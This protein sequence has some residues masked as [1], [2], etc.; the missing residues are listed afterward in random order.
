MDSDKSLEVVKSL[1]QRMVDFLPG[2]KDVP[3]D[4]RMAMAQIAVAHGLDPFLREVWP[5]P[6]RGGGFDLFIGISGW[7]NA[8]HRSGE[9]WGRRF[10]KVSDEERQWLGAAKN[11]LAVRCI[12]MRRKTG[13]QPAE[14]DGYGIA[15]PDEQSKMNKF[16]LARLRAERD[17]MKAAFP[18]STPFNVSVQVASDDDEIINGEHEWQLTGSRI[19]AHDI[20]ISANRHALGRDDGDLTGASTTQPQPDM[21]DELTQATGREAVTNETPEQVAQRALAA[22]AAGTAPAPETMQIDYQMKFNALCIEKN[23]SK[24]I[25]DALLQDAGGDWQ[26]AYEKGVKRYGN[27][28]GKAK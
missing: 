14:Y 26:T 12:V 15:R 21:L 20:D 16:Q 6:K 27:G 2:A 13:Q 3:H 28:V 22:V 23:L 10:E 7:R 17:A 1:E 8:A 25:R 9:Y 4:V 5:I 19:E 11:D 18:I 24:P